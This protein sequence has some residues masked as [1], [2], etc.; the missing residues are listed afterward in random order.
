M[1][2]EYVEAVLT[3]VERI[4]SG[5]VMAYGA[6]AEIVGEKLRRGGPRTV[7]A[8]MAQYGGGVP[9]WR[10]VAASGAVPRASAVVALREL[11]AEGTPMSGDGMRVDMRLAAWHP[12]DL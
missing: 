10:V 11:V 1:D 8:V 12:D 4:P 2:E 5:R 9:W 3:V 6:V 7:G